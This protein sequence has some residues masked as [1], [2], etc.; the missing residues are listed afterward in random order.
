MQ[1][2]LKTRLKWGDLWFMPASMFIMLSVSIVLFFIDLND[3]DPDADAWPAF[4]DRLH[5]IRTTPKN[6]R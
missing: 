6:W 3:R 2:G 4:C 1:S 5:L